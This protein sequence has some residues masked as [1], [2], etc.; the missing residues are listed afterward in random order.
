L[1]NSAQDI[2]SIFQDV[3]TEHGATYFVSFDTKSTRDPFFQGLGSN[4]EFRVRWGNRWATSVLSHLNWRRIGFY[5]KADS[6]LTRLMF[7]ETTAGDGN[8]AY[9]DNVTIARVEP[10][11][12]AQPA[13]FRVTVPLKRTTDL[14]MKSSAIAENLPLNEIH[15]LSG[16]QGDISLE[17]FDISD[18]SNG[19]DRAFET[20]HNGSTDVKKFVNEEMF[21]VLISDQ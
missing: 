20:F 12:S 21:G 18:S 13:A 4:E 1:D 10:L 2:N 6:D 8:G 11:T 17:N 5:V 7:T 14:A 19:Q 9:I 3:P 15:F 16:S